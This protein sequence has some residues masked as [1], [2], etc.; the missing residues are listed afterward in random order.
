MS[1]ILY[2]IFKLPNENDEENEAVPTWIKWW[3]L[4]NYNKKHSWILSE[5][6]TGN[7]LTLE[8]S[9]ETK[10]YLP[11]LPRGN[12]EQVQLTGSNKFN[13]NTTIV[14]SY[15][16]TYTF[17]D[18]VYTITS[19][20]TQNNFSFTLKLDLSTGS[21][22]LNSTKATSDST[23][24]YNSQNE[25]LVN[26]SNNHNYYNFSIAENS[27]S[28]R[29]NFLATSQPVTL[30]LNSLQI[31][32]GT[33]TS[34]TMPAYEP[35]V[36]GTASPNPSYPQD[37]SNV[38]GDVEVLVQNKNL[39]SV[40]YTKENPLRVLSSY[41]VINLDIQ[42]D[43]VKKFIKSGDKVKLSCKVKTD[44]G[45]LTNNQLYLG[46]GTTTAYLP[47]KSVTISTEET[48]ISNYG[49][50]INDIIDGNLKIVMYSNNNITYSAYD[51]MLEKVES[52][53]ATSYV[54]HKEQTL[55]L[56]LGNI[57][58]C[59]IGDYQD[60]FYKDNGKWYLYKNIQK[61]KVDTDTFLLSLSS[62]NN[63]FFAQFIV[64][65]YIGIGAY[66]THF[67]NANNSNISSASSASS[68]MNNGQF[69]M[70][71]GTAPDRIYFKNTAFENN[72]DWNNFFTNNDV[73]VYYVLVTPTSTEITD[74]T[75][76]SQLEAISQA[77]SY[78]EQTNISGSSDE[79]EPLFEVQ[80]Y[81]KNESEGE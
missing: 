26:L 27:T 28:I 72:T 13:K 66:C 20:N 56:T 36:G 58:L 70:K 1:K 63:I 43:N 44:S 38:T 3:L 19:I 29:F 10:F 46:N 37:I 78:E 77:I 81:M 5:I 4:N 11:P 8:N 18:G 21:Y 32:S 33:Y 35:Y 52:D 69:N 40:N 60:Y 49:T 61:V 16:C 71:T 79:A 15:N 17:D 62:A 76:I 59:K 12:S 55:P 2:P 54:K 23:M 39:I 9:V 48:T 31:V 57:E 73:Y 75:L 45:T 68:N 14:G 22:T 47:V 51:F 41:A 24:L 30:D 34:S 53:V 64:P 74:T 7:P 6:I 50:I 80:Y 42:S 67:N 65:N 25:M